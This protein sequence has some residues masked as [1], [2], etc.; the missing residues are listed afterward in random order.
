MKNNIIV[1]M[2]LI[3]I[4]V[5]LFH[6]N[7]TSQESDP[8]GLIGD[9]W[10]CQEQ[11]S[12]T[13]I[14]VFE[15]YKKRKYKGKYF[16]G[17]MSDLA[18]NPNSGNADWALEEDISYT[19]IKAKMKG[20]QLYIGSGKAAMSNGNL[21]WATEPRY[22][23]NP[24]VFKQYNEDE[25]V[26]IKDRASNKISHFINPKLLDYPNDYLWSSN[27]YDLNQVGCW[28]WSMGGSPEPPIK[29]E[30]IVFGKKSGVSL[31]YSKSQRH[32]NI[33]F[34]DIPNPAT[35]VP[36]ASI[37]DVIEPQILET[38]FK[39]YKDWKPI[40]YLPEKNI[41]IFGEQKRYGALITYY[42]LDLNKGTVEDR[43]AP[44]GT[45]LFSNR[46]L[47]KLL[48][49]GVEKRKRVGGVNWI[50]WGNT[51]SNLVF[52][53]L[54]NGVVLDS[55]GTQGAVGNGSSSSYFSPDKDYPLINYRKSESWIKDKEEKIWFNVLHGDIYLLNEKYTEFR[56]RDDPSKNLDI[57]LKIGY[58]DQNNFNFVYNITASDDNIKLFEI[59]KKNHGIVKYIT[60]SGLLGSFDDYRSFFVFNL[61]KNGLQERK[62]NSLQKKNNMLSDEDKQYLKQFF[63]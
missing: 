40:Q 22:S 36:P 56:Y 41:M 38:Q 11:G 31:Q 13:R 52:Y 32:L 1:R 26:M 10:Y 20:D 45:H 39:N 6:N 55:I 14:L 15:S 17:H 3:T 8:L 61:N 48:I 21:V 30:G 24:I 62:I 28:G 35:G 50:P 44:N 29:I 58:V 42:L 2:I 7:G 5:T 49:S 60:E 33:F 51:K 47:G 54:I 18:I 46:F 19:T 57:S 37:T 9:K 4:L 43:K 59:I 63:E 25:M 12:F 53:D 23:R 27:G 16:N 34:D